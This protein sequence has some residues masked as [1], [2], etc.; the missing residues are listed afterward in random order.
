MDLRHIENEWIINPDIDDPSVLYFESK[1]ALLGSSKTDGR[2]V[3]FKSINNLILSEEDIP[4][5]HQV[6]CAS[7]GSSDI[8]LTGF[9]ERWQLVFKNKK[10]YLQK[11]FIIQSSSIQKQVLLSE[12]YEILFL[13]KFKMM[14]KLKQ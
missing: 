10:P 12:I 3:V 11:D 6:Y 8:S 5:N 1:N 13:T 2:F 14:L 4:N 7:P 9:W